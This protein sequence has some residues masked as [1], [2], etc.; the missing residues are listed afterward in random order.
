MFAI[1]Y[2][3]NYF[4]L[5]HVFQTTSVNARWGRPWLIQPQSFPKCLSRLVEYDDVIRG[6]PF[7]SCLGPPNPKPTTALINLKVSAICTFQPHPNAVFFN[8]FAAAEPSL[9][10]CVAHGT[11]YNDPSV[12]IITTAQ[13]CGC[14]FRPRQFRSVSVEPLAVTRGTQSFRG[15]TIETH[16]PNVI[17]FHEGKLRPV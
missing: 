5:L 3:M 6:N 14:E 9:N 2:M 10:V 1:R 12:F 4:L 13:N 16:C 11:Q 15:T 7:Q 17:K 8:L